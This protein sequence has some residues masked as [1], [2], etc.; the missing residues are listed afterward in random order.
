MLG[1]D[2]RARRAVY[3]EPM[4]HAGDVTPQQAHEAL[5]ADPAA[6]LVDVRTQAEWSYVGVP[7]LA[8]LGKDLVT[9]EWMTFPEGRTNDGFVDELARAGV[10]QDAPVYFLCRSGARSDAAASAAA[11][12][13]WSRAHN[14][15]QGFEGALSAQRHR[16]VDGWRN[17]GL[18]W[19]QG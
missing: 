3:A 19:V 11:A 1:G 6:V 4:S 5:A 7:D 18:P 17:A 2:R 9:I 14:V 13:G 10:A 15:A 16:D 12:A 8:P